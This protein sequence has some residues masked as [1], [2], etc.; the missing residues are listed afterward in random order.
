MLTTLHNII[1]PITINNQLVTLAEKDPSVGVQHN[2]SSFFIYKDKLLAKGE[3]K[4]PNPNQR[5]ARIT[6]FDP[7]SGEIKGNILYIIYLFE[8]YFLILLHVD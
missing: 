1:N 8:I 2:W 4:N 3:Y 7:T 5:S 6:L